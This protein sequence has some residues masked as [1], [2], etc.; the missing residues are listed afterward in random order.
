MKFSLWTHNG[1][2]NSGPVFDSFAHGVLNAGGD[3]IY[4]NINSDVAVIWSVLWYGRMSSNKKVWDLFRSQNKPV[5]VLE[6]GGIKRGTTWKVGING[7][8]REAI[9]GPKN[10]GPDRAELFNLKLKPWRVDGEYII[11]CGQHDKSHQWRNQPS[12]S[13]WILDTI[14]TIR[15]HT[16]KTI[17]IRPHPRSPFPLIEYEFKGVQRQ[18]P[19]KLNGTYDDFDFNYDNS[20]AV[21]NWS[22]NPATQAVIDGVPVFVGPESLAWDVGNKEL[23][24]IN[25]PHMPNRQQ[26]LND[27]AYT[28]W[29]TEE[30]AKGLPLKLLTPYL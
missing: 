12:M 29:T 10:N 9:F 30:I 15:E 24:N 19:Q 18:T 4:N 25:N 13:N 27:L 22:S 14:A 16:E 2:K 5:I 7:I 21:I 6:V 23:K 17:I 1:A 3:V 8:N 20:W 11:I 26:W 28:E